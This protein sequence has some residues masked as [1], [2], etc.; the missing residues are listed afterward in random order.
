LNAFD[1]EILINIDGESL[2]CKKIIE[3]NQMMKEKDKFI[4][5]MKF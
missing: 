2:N 5:N 3:L 1:Q 4:D